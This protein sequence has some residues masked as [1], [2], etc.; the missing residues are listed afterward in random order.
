MDAIYALRGG[1]MTTLTDS[2]G[3]PLPPDIRALFESTLRYTHKHFLNGI[4]TTEEVELFTYDD[5]GRFTCGSGFLDRLQNLAGQQFVEIRQGWPEDGQRFYIDYNNLGYDIVLKPDQEECVARLLAA[6][7]GQVD[8]PPGFGKSFILTALAR[9]LPYARIHVVASARDVLRRIYNEII[10]YIPGVGMVDGSQQNWGRVTLISASSLHKVDY[11]DFHSPRFA[12]VVLGDEV[13]TLAAAKYLPWLARYRFALM[14]A[15]S[16]T[17]NKRFDNADFAMEGL[18][19]PVLYRM[20]YQESQARGLVVPIDVEWLRVT[21]AHDP[22]NGVHPSLR[23][24]VGLWRNYERNRIIA[25]RVLEIPTDEQVLVLV[26]TVDHAVHLGQLLPHFTLCYD[27]VQPVVYER[28]VRQEL[29]DPDRNPIMTPRRRLEMVRDFEMGELRHVI[30][31]D[32]WSTGVSF[33]QLSYMVRADG[34]SSNIKNVQAPGRVSRV[35]PEI[36]KECGYVLDC[37]DEFNF[38]RLRSSQTRY[39][40]Y[41]NEGWTQRLPP[42]VTFHKGGKRSGRTVEPGSR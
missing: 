42:G 32:V 37:W 28:Y 2:N 33:R 22:E 9:L 16:A 24:R 40:A 18:F 7:C 29:V 39:R 23:H 35:C 17:I 14:Y 19:G 26:S 27:K 21:M 20:T 10:G 41:E 15:L 36:S 31:T 13:H 4:V 30:C 12:D 1:N 11:D 25:N 38:A 6:P 34:R 3:G 5:Y 8:A